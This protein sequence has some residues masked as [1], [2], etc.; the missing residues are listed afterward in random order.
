[1]ADGVKVPLTFRIF[2]G[3]QLVRTENLT[4]DIV[5]IGKLSSSHLRIDDEQVSRMHAVIEVTGPDEVNI[6][7]LGST[8]G[9]IVN[10]QRVNKAKLQDGDTIVLGDTKIEIAIGA[11]QEAEDAP[12]MVSDQPGGTRPAAASPPPPSVSASPSGA[13]PIMASSPRP[14]PAQAP[15]IT[16]PAPQAP[17]YAPPPAAA[18]IPAPFAAAAPPPRA[19]APRPAAPAHAAVSGASAFAARAP[20]NTEGVEDSTG[21]RAVEVAAMFEDQV[22]DVA[23]L[24]NPQSGKISG[25]TK[26]IGIGAVLALIITVICFQQALSVAIRDKHAYNKHTDGDPTNP[27]PALRVPQ[28]GNTF[29]HEEVPVAVEFGF[30][31]GF[32]LTVALAWSFASRSREEKRPSEFRLGEGD[33]VEFNIASSM[34]GNMPAFPLVRSTGTDWTFNFMRNWGGDVTVDGRT[35]TLE[36]VAASG[37]ATGSSAAPGAYEMQIPLNARIKVDIGENTF[38]VNS[39]PPPRRHPV[40]MLAT[41]DTRFFAYLGASAVGAAGV[42]MLLWAIPP[43]E[44]NTFVENPP[45][46]STSATLENKANEAVEQPEEEEPNKDDGKESG[47]TGTKTMGPEG[48]MGKK[49]YKGVDGRYNIMDR[50]A[51]KGL[52]MQKAAERGANSG[53]VGALARMEGDAFGHITGQLPFSSGFGDRDIQGGL[54][55]DSFGEAS[56]GWGTG[57]SGEGWGGGGTGRGTI[58]LGNYGTLGWGK[59]TGTGFG[60]G[61]GSGS[62]RGHTKRRPAVNLGQAEGVGDLD[63]EMIRREI[64]KNKSK[65]EYCYEKQLLAKPNLEGTVSTQFA[66]L[67]TGSV[68]GARANGVDPSVSSCV[69]QVL[70][71]IQFPKP[72]GGGVVNVSYPFTFRQAGE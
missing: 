31:V 22:H 11:S 59:G 34:V 18:S 42:L 14:A 3:D 33:H 38:L 64:R 47:G 54:T 61:S 39:V 24:T 53:I 63:K 57:V 67:G 72:T 58:G 43:E 65:F 32:A 50:G 62:G 70:G 71:G 48:K 68:R 51:D 2:K 69:A 9:T 17:V 35:E 25:M 40:S 5:K 21:A 19:A 41:L 13:S 55:G 8:R 46:L 44:S 20:M 29:E 23:H 28:P 6:I 52:G 49:D 30:V 12:T 4:Q 10:G 26:G 16:A 36:Q 1:M 66:I 37:R 60:T 7:D 27:D 56:G 45:K 15:T